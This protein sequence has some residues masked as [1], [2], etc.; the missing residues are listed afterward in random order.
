M[1]QSRTAALDRQKFVQGV[2]KHWA[3]GPRGRSNGARCSVAGQPACVLYWCFTGS[4]PHKRSGTGYCRRGVGR[5]ATVAI[6]CRARR[7]MRPMALDHG[8]EKATTESSPC[9]SLKGLAP[10]RR[11]PRR[12][13]HEYSHRSRQAAG[14]SAQR[15]GAQDRTAQA[16]SPHM[17]SPRPS[18]SMCCRNPRRHF[19]A[20]H[21]ACL[22]S[23][24]HARCAQA[25]TLL[26]PA[27]VL[28]SAL[29]R[30]KEMPPSAP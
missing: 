14:R 12:P 16:A 29:V 13:S 26:R 25:R 15:L 30:Q 17:R 19:S 8:R 18:D 5:A 10:G 23:V 3:G 24:R 28:G 9:R 2:T 4:R 6:L 20:R 22:A 27:C 1:T 11:R 21:A 7:R